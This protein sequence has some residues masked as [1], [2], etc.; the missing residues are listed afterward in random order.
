MSV[1]EKEISYYKKVKKDLL[2][3]HKDEYVLISEEKVLGT[4]TKEED[5]IANG[6]QKSQKIPFLVRK[7]SHKEEVF[8]Y[9]LNVVS[10]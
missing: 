5:A 6:Y 1:L 9:A 2:S 3:K 8:E 4:F 10:L 7:I